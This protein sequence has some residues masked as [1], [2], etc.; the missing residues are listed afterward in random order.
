MPR[1]LHERLAILMIE[2]VGSRRAILACLSSMRVRAEAGQIE[3][4]ELLQQV[5]V[6][7]AAKD[8]SPGDQRGRSLLH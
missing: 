1:N 3:R 2:A 5:I 4:V 6:A 8:L 7:I